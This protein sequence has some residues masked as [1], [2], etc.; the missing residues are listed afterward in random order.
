MDIKN[1]LESK[2][3]VLNTRAKALSDVK[4][5]WESSIVINCKS[6]SSKKELE[7]SKILD[8]FAEYKKRPAIYFFKIVSK[9]NKQDVINALERYKNTRKRSCPK[10]D[11]K[12]NLNSEYLYCGS[13]KEGLHG[14]FIQHIGFG[15]ANTFALQLFH[16]ARALDSELILEFHYAWLDVSQK[17]LTELIE[18]ALAEKLSPLVGKIA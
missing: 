7:N 3:N 8:V 18:S 15:S 5:K 10:I 4:I 2:V 17:E 16:W 1:N 12:R 9:Q 13:K 11:K 6:L 14:R